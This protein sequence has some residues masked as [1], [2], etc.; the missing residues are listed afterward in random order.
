MPK[1]PRQNK[2][3]RKQIDKSAENLNPEGAG[4][5]AACGKTHRE[6]QEVSG[7]KKGW[8]LAPEGKG[9]YQ[10][11]SLPAKNGRQF[12]KYPILKDEINM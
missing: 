8:A 11:H 7:R 3:S 2:L 5:F 6:S 1:P 12:A 4:S 9:S 10:T